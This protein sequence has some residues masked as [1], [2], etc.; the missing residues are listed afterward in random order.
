LRLIPQIAEKLVSL[1]KENFGEDC[2]LYLFGSRVDDSKKGGDID[3]LLESKDE[4]SSE[5]KIMFLANVQRNITERK[6]DLLIADKNRKDLEIVR[7]AKETG[8]EL[9]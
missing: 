9:C 4:V 3:L 8:I 1:A 7:I 5:Q 2:K 6:V